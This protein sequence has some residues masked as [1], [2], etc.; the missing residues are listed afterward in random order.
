MSK[1]IYCDRCNKLFL[2]DVSHHSKIEFDRYNEVIF[3]GDLCN[4]CQDALE[5]FLERKKKSNGDKIQ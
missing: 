2:E 1:A 5:D 4:K 3:D